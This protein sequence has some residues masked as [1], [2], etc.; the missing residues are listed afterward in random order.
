[1]VARIEIGKSI[2]GI[3]HYNENKVAV[4]E[5]K[6]IMASGFAGE[7]EE[8]TFMNKLKRFNHLTHL[9]PTVETNALHISLN[10]DSSENISD[11]KMQQIA[12]VYMDKIGF[13]EQPYL[14]YRHSDS[15]HH[16]FHIATVSIQRN[17]EAIPLHNIGCILSEPARKSI[18]KEFDIVVAESKN[19]KQESGIKPVDLEKAK[20]GRLST[21]KQISNV[22]TAVVARYKFGSIPEL[23]AV[24]REFNVTVDRGK[25]GSEMFKKWGLLYS[26]IDR[27]GNK[28]GKPIKGSAF[29][30]KPIT[31]I[32][33]KKFD[34]NIEK[35]K[36]FRKELTSK[37]NKVLSK[38][39]GISI[40]TLNAELKKVGVGLF[41]R[42]N[43]QGRIYGTTFIDHKNMVVFNGSDLGK[44]YSANAIAEQI[45]TSDQLRTFLNP[46]QSPT[47]YLKSQP[48]QSANTYLEPNTGT[49]FLNDLLGKAEPD[50]IPSK[51]RK[52]KRRNRGLTL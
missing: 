47:T 44:P 46:I 27:N 1:M 25:E 20:Y 48:E 6:L 49:N 35:R 36:P 38:Y 3:L 32:I 31:R 7:I 29:Y 21:K 52:K 18:E 26:I 51:L 40:D 10:F 42:K 4:G 12:N 41:L 33:E 37:I 17:G 34:R 14:I 16:H 39:K 22:V 19:Y 28:V 23:N 30:S 2:E 13:G 15:G 45:S 5:A 50:Y 8:M 24:L 11:S 43:D 9:R